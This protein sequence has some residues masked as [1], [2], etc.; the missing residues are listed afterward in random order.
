MVTMLGRGVY[1]FA[2]AARLTGLRPARISEWFRG[3]RSGPTN[4]AVFQG[5]Y[6]VDGDVAISFFD[7]IDVY[8]AG[9]LRDHGVSLRTVRKVYSRME[10]DLGTPHPFCRKELL[11]DGKVEFLKGLD[12][13]GQQELNEVLTR[14][15][16]FPRVLLPFLKQI[17]YDQVQLTAKRWRIADKVVVDPA[18]CFGKPVVEQAGV[19]TSLLADTY[20]AN[21]EDARR[22]ADWYNVS[23]ADVLAAVEFE[24]KLAA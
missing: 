2:E 24:S 17:D 6:P 16:V 23:P 21:N 12:A 3:R 9:Q 7:L 13:A 18:I 8:V 5:D 11:T 14:Q 19:P 20:R 10:Q 4:W 22:V 1:T 15:K